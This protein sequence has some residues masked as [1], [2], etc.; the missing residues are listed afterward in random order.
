MSTHPP[1]GPSAG[2]W[3]LTTGFKSE[4]ASHWGTVLVV[5][6]ELGNRRLLSHLL[7]AEGYAVEC[8]AD[9]EAAL[10]RIEQQGPDLI[11][12]D[13]QLPGI[14]GFSVCRQVK[15]DPRTR[16][17][18]IVLMTGLDAREHRIEGIQ[19]GADDFIS[20][21]FD[22]EELQARVRSLVRAKRYTDQLDSAE[23]IIMSLAC[24]IEARDAYTQGHCERLAQYAMALGSQVRLTIEEVSALRRGAFLHDIGK[25]GIP[26]TVLLKQDRLTPTEYELMKQ[27]PVIGDRLCGKLQSL[28]LV[29]P[30]VRHHHER[31]DGTGYPDGLRGQDVPLLAQIVSIV[32]A[33]DAITTD[34][35]YRVAR[36]PE[37]AYRELLREAS[38]GWRDADLVDI[39][40]NLG[41]SGALSGMSHPYFP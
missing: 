25:I 21:P 1:D 13:V 20:K 17:T 19:A 7:R 5:D 16:L 30:I 4:K 8:F 14:D 37:E 15:N 31:L 27:H 3:G 36:S 6:D 11:L 12:L 32:D 10:R 38:R 34:R 40:S 23:A 9:G 26:D 24:T 22:K 18:P 29:R 2:G 39:L 28:D 35:P 33:Y 41:R